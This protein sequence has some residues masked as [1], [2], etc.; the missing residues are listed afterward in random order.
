MLVNGIIY[1]SIFEQKL[2]RQDGR[3]RIDCDHNDVLSE[4]FDEECH[5]MEIVLN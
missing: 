5:R 2:E 3:D 1:K 4:E